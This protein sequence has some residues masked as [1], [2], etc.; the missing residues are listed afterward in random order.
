MDNKWTYKWY[1]IWLPFGMTLWIQSV[2]TLYIVLL[3]FRYDFV[4]FSLTNIKK[5]ILT[6]DGFP[7]PGKKV[8]V[9]IRYI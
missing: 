7:L 1:D 8:E 3:H 4:T 9:V 6:I 2:Y 5:P